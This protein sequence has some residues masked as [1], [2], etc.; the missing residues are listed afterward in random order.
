MSSLLCR[1]LF[2]SSAPRYVQVARIKSFCRNSHSSKKSSLTSFA[3]GKN[4]HR[5][6][7]VGQQVVLF[8]FGTC[9]TSGSVNIA[10]CEENN[11][12]IMTK[13]QNKVSGAISSD[14]WTVYADQIASEIGGKLND[15]INTGIPVKI[16]YGFAS[17]FCSGY[18]LK[19]VG[20]AGSFV[21]GVGF[22]GLQ[23]L[24]YAGYIHVDFDKM[25]K[26]FSKALDMNEDGVVDELDIR[27][28]YGKIM[29][30]LEFNVPA[31]SG[32][33]AGFLMGLRTA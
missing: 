30:V 5:H 10:Q 15:A 17:G 33:G 21:L 23:G 32:F 13:I 26:D 1:S 29:D 25:N 19:K 6:S 16:S 9:L 12:D 27:K 24:A 18:A 31:G 20:R 22:C 7:I 4:T 28:G 3:G 2:Q 8:M 14:V 11:D